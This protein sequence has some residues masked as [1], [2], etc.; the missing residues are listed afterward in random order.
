MHADVLNVTKDL[1]RLFTSM[2]LRPKNQEFVVPAALFY[3]PRFQY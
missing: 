1:L 3:L 2:V